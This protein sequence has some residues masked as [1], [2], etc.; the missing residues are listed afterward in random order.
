MLAGL[1]D[2]LPS[3]ELHC[4]SLCPRLCFFRSHTMLIIH[5]P[6]MSGEWCRGSGSSDPGVGLL[7]W[8]GITP[9]R[10]GK[11]CVARGGEPPKALCRRAGPPDRPERPERAGTAPEN[12]VDLT[13]PSRTCRRALHPRGRPT[14]IRA[15]PSPEF[16]SRINRGKGDEPT[17]PSARLRVEADGRG[18]K[19]RTRGRGP[20]HLR[21]MTR[22]SRS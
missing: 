17:Q 8:G 16:Q 11:P 15:S 3:S 21:Q 6:T 5:S 2:G 14:R 12:P 22:P 13:V 7:V 20:G 1:L 18:E 10:H 9:P 4:D 19:G